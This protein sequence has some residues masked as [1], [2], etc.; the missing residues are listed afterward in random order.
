MPDAGDQHDRRV[1]AAH[2]RGVRGGVPV[3]VGLVVLAVGRVQ[4]VQPGDGVLDRGVGRQVQD[5][6]LDLGAQE[7]VGAGRCPARASRGCSAAARKSSTT[8]SSVKWPTTAACR[9]GQAA[10]RRGQRGGLGPPLGLRQRAVALQRRAEGL[11]PA[12]LGDVRR[13]RVDDP[14]A[15]CSASA[16]VSPQAVMPCPP[17]MQPMACGVA[18]LMA[19]MSRPSWK[20]GPAPGHPD[21]G[22]AEDLRGQGLAVGRGGD[23]DARRRGA[24]GRR[25]RRP[26][27]RAS[28]CRSTARRRPCRAGSSRTP[29]PS[30]PRA[31]RP[32]RR[33]PAP[34]AGPAAAP[35]APARSA[36]RGRRRSP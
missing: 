10:E 20:P 4:L 28:R 29:P 23:R 36:C 35:P 34:A 22:V 24:G 9:G 25:A 31:P 3:V 5:Q 2:G 11:G 27:A 14:Q 16:L 33:W 13:G 7:V 1:G 6:R 18:A 21:D 32:G 12:V 26:P 17:R 19:A 15:C 30:R 8:A